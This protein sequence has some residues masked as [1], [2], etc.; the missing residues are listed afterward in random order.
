MSNETTLCAP[1][2]KVIKHELGSLVLFGEAPDRL[3]VRM[4]ERVYRKDRLTQIEVGELELNIDPWAV[5]EP[6]AAYS[7]RPLSL[8]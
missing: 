6:V 4:G 2:H 7:A 3:T 5:R 1:H 8:Q